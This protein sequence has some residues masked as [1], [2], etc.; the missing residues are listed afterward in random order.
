MVTNSIAKKINCTGDKI[1]SGALIASGEFFSGSISYNNN[2]NNWLI[3]D[4]VN[5]AKM[6][7]ILKDITFNKEVKFEILAYDEYP[8]KIQYAN[9]WDKI[10]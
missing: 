8:K 9:N 1:T 10:D 5:K 3:F 2:K 6:L 7:Y 4:L